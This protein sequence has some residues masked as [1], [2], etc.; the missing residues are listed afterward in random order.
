MVLSVKRVKLTYVSTTLF[1]PLI[2]S[3][4]ISF[5]SIYILDISEYYCLQ[6]GA[7]DKTYNKPTN[8]PEWRDDIVIV[9]SIKSARTT[10]TECYWPKP[11]FFFFFSSLF[12]CHFFSNLLQLLGVQTTQCCNLSHNKVHIHAPSLPS[13]C[14]FFIVSFSFLCFLLL[15]LSNPIYTY[16]FFISLSLFLW[17]LNL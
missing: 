7:Q 8:Q 13:H 16:F 10:F 3:L 11:Y 9:Y 1:S 6:S 14:I 4:T 12:F 2:L 17:P 5:P 15:F